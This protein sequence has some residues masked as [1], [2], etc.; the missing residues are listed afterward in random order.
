MLKKS[1]V[2]WTLSQL[3]PCDSNS[4]CKT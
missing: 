2:F 3:V 1:I 4:R